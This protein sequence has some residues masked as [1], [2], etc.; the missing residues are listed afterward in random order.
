MTEARLKQLN[1]MSGCMGH[2]Q[3]ILK[4]MNED[5]HPHF[6]VTIAVH[7]LDMSYDEMNIKMYPDFEQVFKQFLEHY[8]AELK[9]SFDAA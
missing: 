4:A 3:E 6:E 5:N 1:E 2:L 7:D 9:K 8:Y